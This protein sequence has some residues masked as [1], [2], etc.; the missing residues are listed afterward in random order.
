MSD[1]ILRKR[2]A[3]QGLVVKGNCLCVSRIHRNRLGLGSGVDD[4]PRSG[5]DL[6]RGRITID[7]LEPGTTITAKEIKVPEGV[8]LDT[9]PKSIQITPVMYSPLFGPMTALLESVTRKVTPFRG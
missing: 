4:V 3:A 9:L 7:N 6:L 2:E 1:P 5:G 8:I